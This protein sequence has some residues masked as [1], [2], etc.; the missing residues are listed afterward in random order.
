MRKKKEDPPPHISRYFAICY[1]N[2]IRNNPPPNIQPLCSPLVEGV[3]VKRGRAPLE[4]TLNYI[5]AQHIYKYNSA[6]I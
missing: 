4:N 1:V 6:Q 2:K 5:S 3:E